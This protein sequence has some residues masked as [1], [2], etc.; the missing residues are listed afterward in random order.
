MRY[1]IAIA[2]LVACPALAHDWYPI[3]CCAEEDCEILPDE[4]VERRTDGYYIIPLGQ[5]IPYNK[6]NSSP[7]NNFHWC[8]PWEG[9]EQQDRLILSLDDTPVLN[10]SRICFFAPDAG[11]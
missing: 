11:V 1:A 10:R 9:N 3:E 8:R 5:V 2:A 6:A 7:D 4:F